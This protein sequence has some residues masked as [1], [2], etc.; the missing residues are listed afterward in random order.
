MAWSGAVGKHSA[1][2]M[3]C[4]AIFGSRRAAALGMLTGLGIREIMLARADLEHRGQCTIV[5][6]PGIRSEA[7]S[8]TM[9]NDLDPSRSYYLRYISAIISCVLHAIYLSH[10]LRTRSKALIRMSL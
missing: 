5:R 9:R 1:V 10:L 7:P 8:L 4:S 6:R 3:R 2:E